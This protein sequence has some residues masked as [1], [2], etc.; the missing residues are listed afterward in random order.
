MDTPNEEA[1][2]RLIYKRLHATWCP[3]HES[4]EYCEWLVYGVFKTDPELSDLM[5]G[6][7]LGLS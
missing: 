4:T 5:L 7:P 6:F 1:A 3:N 2:L